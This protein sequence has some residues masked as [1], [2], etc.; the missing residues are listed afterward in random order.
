[1]TGTT[2]LIVVSGQN[3]ALLLGVAIAALTLVISRRHAAIVTL[4]LLAPYVILVGADPPV[5]RAA[6]MSVGIALAS[7]TGRRTPGW[8]YLLYAV[9]AMLAVDPRLARDVAFQLSATATAGVML[10]A[11]PLCDA[12]FARLPRTAE[13]ARAAF[14]EA[15]ATTTGAS[16]AV[17]PVQVAAF[18]RLAPW[19]VPAN[20]LVAPLYEATFAVS[21]VAACIGWI[22]PLAHAFG[23]VAHF[24]P[25]AFLALVRLL[26]QLPGAEVPVAAPILAGVA[27]YALL[28]LATWQLG[29]RTEDEAQQL[30]LTRSRSSHLAGVVLLTVVAGGLWI[31]VL[32]PRPAL[33]SVTVLDV[34][35]ALAVLVEDGGRRV[36]VDAG[37]PDGAALRALPRVGASSGLDVIVVSHVDADHSGG[38]QE[39]V[40]RL[41]VGDVRAGRGV[42]IPGGVP[43]D[44][45]DIGD[46]IRVSDRVTIEV[47]AP[48]AATRPA[49]LTSTNDT[50]IVLLVHIGD[51]RILLPADIEHGGEQW[52]AH[53]GLDLRADAIVVP[54]HGSTTSSSREFL[55]A[56]QPRVA[57]ISVGARNAYG[58]PAPEVV[59]RYGGVA[60]YRTDESGDV[61]LRSDGS[62]MWVAAQHRSRGAHAHGTSDGYASVGV[63]PGASAEGARFG[64]IC[65]SASSAISSPR[66]PRR[67]PPRPVVS[68]RIASPTTS[69][70]SLPLESPTTISPDTTTPNDGTARC[71]PGRAPTSKRISMTRLASPITAPPTPLNSPGPFSNGQSNRSIGSRCVRPRSSA[72]S[73]Y[74]VIAVPRSADS[75]RATRVACYGTGPKG[76]RICNVPMKR[77]VAS[78][79]PPT[80]RCWCWRWCSPR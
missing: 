68:T 40:Q 56:V 30:T 46:R 21:T 44:E 77:C 36:L 76:P 59:A 73:R 49:S 27:F 3:I 60:L 53:S 23:F 69:V 22:V 18:D 47:L 64:G 37:P 11:P 75:C 35:Q 17:L 1:M 32:T 48:P 78:K 24:A 80:C 19:S 42:Q 41:S 38:V 71:S 43:H 58:H 39:L 63:S 13:G 79:K 10:V 6:I 67:Q 74:A 55:D 45:I 65:T 72:V 33:A 29:Q 31:V 51:R 2:H 16:L 8:V 54:H 61:T 34:G 50:G 52:L 70:A 20:I 12:V 4:G 57:V 7:V 9:A 62:R 66:L 26:A 25:A 14:V 5:M 15:A 28:A